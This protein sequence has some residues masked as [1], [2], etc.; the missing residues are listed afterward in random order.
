M[1][2]FHVTPATVQQRL[3]L[4]QPGDEI[5]LQAGDYRARLRL[6]GRS[7]TAAMPITVRADP[8]AHLDQ[9][10]D[11]QAY[12][13]RG[14]QL[15]QDVYEG[16]VPGYPVHAYPGLYPWM[17]DGQLVLDNCRHVRLLN[18][19][20]RQSWPTLIALVDC[21]HI[22]IG[23]ATLLDGTFAI[24]ARGTTTSDISIHDCTWVQD[25]VANRMWR[26][27]DW[28]RIHGTPGDK[29]GWPMNQVEDWRLFDGD[30]FRG[31]DIAG[32]IRV[33]RCQVTAAFN[34]IHLFNPSRNR[35]LCRDVEV[36]HCTFTEIRDNIF[37]AEDMAYNWWFHHNEI[38]NAHKWFSIEQEDTGYFY[39]FANRAWYDSIQGPKDDKHSQGGV[40]K[41]PTVE[42][43]AGGTLYVFNNSFCT[44]GS[45][46]GNGLLTDVVHQN[47]A[48]R[49]AATADPGFDP[50][51]AGSVFGDLTAAPGDIDERFTT[52]W[53][54]LQ[55]RMRNDV[56]AHASWPGG[57]KNAGYAIEPALGTDP[58]FIN[59]SRGD[60][61]L[62]AGS[63]CSGASRA[64]DVEL[65]DGN[66]WRAPDT[67]DI[68]AWQGGSLFA[69][70]PFVASP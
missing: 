7:G 20:I 62:A 63:P 22:E 9:G 54:R 32:G 51:K 46:L 48:V 14:N 44:H 52:E 28:R 61:K 31:Y 10:L 24:A 8:G 27:I 55:I 58:A 5:V 29:Y 56:L 49:L 4:A 23:G 30:F 19:S 11:A 57:V 16:R 25:V 64:F 45:Y 59:W 50:A 42:P 70:P 38:V 34:A 13:V 68:G 37:E 66:V 17:K 21:R 41:I 15:S 1:P 69:G 53:S 40:F 26:E 35:N 2:V 43:V 33:L 65:V 3:N 39:F 47:N 12:R 6:Q 67:G 36:A 18:L 60:L